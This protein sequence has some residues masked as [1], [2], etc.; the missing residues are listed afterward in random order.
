MTVKGLIN[1]LEK[2]DED[3]QVYITCTYDCGCGT[4]GGNRIEIFEELDRVELYN[5]EC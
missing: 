4:A 2:Y 3:K 1:E 5:D